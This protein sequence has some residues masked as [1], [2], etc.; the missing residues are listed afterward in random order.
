MTESLKS[1]KVRL[2]KQFNFE[3]A[4]ALYGYDGPCRNIHGHSYVLEVTVTGE[5]LE[6]PASPKNGMVMDFSE[7]KNIVKE[8][9]ISKVDH[10]LV[11]NADSPHGALTEL[12][13]H[14]E[15]L[16]FVPFQPTCENMLLD[17][18]NVLKMML[19][20][21]VSLH[22]VL[23]RETPKSFAEWYATDNS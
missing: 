23:L 19:P 1:L 11:L 14:F 16:I 4:H 2:T 8:Q 22:H 17:F 12:E 9:I 7:L 6:D 13:N 5:P 15:K 18:V 10:A 21:R 3:M 20:D